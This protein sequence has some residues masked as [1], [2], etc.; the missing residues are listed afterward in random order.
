MMDTIWLMGVECK[1]HLG[2]PD[3]ERKNLQ[4]VLLDIGLELPLDD[5]ECSDDVQDTV[6]YAAVEKE[7]RRIAESGEYRLAERLAYVVAQ[8][9]LNIDRRI[10]KAIIAV[11]KN[12]SVMPGTREVVVS[13]SVGRE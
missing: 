7:A 13:I 2:V 8:S 9:V 4:K 11:H 3:A 12:P 5:A 1:A 6:D 10:R